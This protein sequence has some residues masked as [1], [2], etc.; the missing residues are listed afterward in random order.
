MAH[1]G[2]RYRKYPPPP[3]ICGS[4]SEPHLRTRDRLWPVSLFFGFASLAFTGEPLVPPCSPSLRAGAWF[5][6][7]TSH[8][9]GS[10]L[11][12][13]VVSLPPGKARLRPQLVLVSESVRSLARSL[14]TSLES[15]LTVRR[16]RRALP[17]GRRRNTEAARRS[18]PRTAPG[19]VVPQPRSQGGGLR[20]NP[21]GSPAVVTSS[22]PCPACRRRRR[23]G[24]SPAARRRLPRWSG[25][26]SRSKPRSAAPSA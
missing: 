16:R 22:R 4:T 25:C 3:S 6:R 1:T 8:P 5:K 2:G 18:M 15:P 10:V 14:T 12:M 20:G 9:L 23:P 19:T 21:G 26:S 11:H 7:F 17:A 13:H 24:S